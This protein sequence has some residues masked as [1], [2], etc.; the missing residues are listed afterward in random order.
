ML[1]LGPNF[2]PPAP[3]PLGSKYLVLGGVC[4]SCFVLGGGGGDHKGSRIR[5]AEIYGFSTTQLRGKAIKKC[6]KNIDCW[7]NR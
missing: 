6:Q 2:E 3:Q 4:G 5:G 7:L 1:G